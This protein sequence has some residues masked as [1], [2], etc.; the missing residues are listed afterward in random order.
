MPS[1]WRRRSCP[2]VC[3][4]LHADAAGTGAG[5]LDLGFE[6]HLGNIRLRRVPQVE[7]TRVAPLSELVHP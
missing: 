6:L 7:V 4:R 3:R 2:R 5:E 1:D